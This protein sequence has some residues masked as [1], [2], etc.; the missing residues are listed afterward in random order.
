MTTARRTE[1]LHVIVRGQVQGV[2]FR[3]F[4]VRLADQLDLT[5]WV[6]NRPDRALELVAEGPPG[7]LDEL[8]EALHEGP[9]A[10]PQA[11]YPGTKRSARTGYPLNA[12]WPRPSRDGTNVRKT[13]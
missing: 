12:I 10:T 5:G 1:R 3:W 4:V 8:L 7:R 2:G 11:R 6:M 9:P 13:R